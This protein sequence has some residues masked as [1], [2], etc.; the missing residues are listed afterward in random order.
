MR[1]LPCAC[2]ALWP[3]AASASSLASLEAYAN[4]HTGGVVA[5]VNGDT[6]NNATVA[7][8]WRPVAG[9]L[10]GAVGTGLALVA[11][12]STI[13]PTWDGLLLSEIPPA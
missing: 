6:N 12:A 4:L 2:L 11:A 10:S 8:E 7:L 9:F 1:L 5:V 13:E 3:A